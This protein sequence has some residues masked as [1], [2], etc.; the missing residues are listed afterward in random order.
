MKIF[1]KNNKKTLVTHNGSFHTDDVFAAAALSLLLEKQG[2]SFEIIRTR[3]EDIIKKGDFV[4][5]VGG[6]Y[7]ES[8]NRFDHHQ[9]SGA[10][11]HENKIPYSSFGLIWKSYGETI[12]GSTRARDI[13]NKK[14]VQPVDAFD[15]GVALTEKKYD[16][17][18]YLIQN[19]FFAMSPTWLE[20]EEKL[21]QFF[22]QSVSVAKEI[23]KR[24]IIWTNDA[25]LAEE[26]VLEYYKKTE[27]KRIITFDQKYPF[28]EFLHPFPEP[29]FVVY[30]RKQ[31]L[32]GVKAVQRDLR[33]FNN[34]KNL[35]VSW[36][37]LR[38]EELQ[39]ITGVSDAVFC[40]RG[41][42]MAVAKSREGAI[43]L[44]QIALES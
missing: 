5:D 16:A 20:G 38:E 6:T 21:D 37:G 13:I 29:I 2:D 25:L 15:N 32:W 17:I 43:K 28:Q 22:F 42:F 35:P 4:F 19:V 33:S 23:L 40:H 8:K 14:L 27:D 31:G 1:N 39:K 7:D 12:S 24:E 36:A 3:D 9:A 10:G 41:L 18:P 11:E 44:A 34:R 26:K 30:P